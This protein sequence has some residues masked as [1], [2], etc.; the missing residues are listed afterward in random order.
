M[1]H[2]TKFVKFLTESEEWDRDDLDD[3]LRP[4]KDMGIEVSV[5]DKKPILNGENEGR[6][7]TIIR[8]GI[9]GLKGVYFPSF[10]GITEFINDERIWEILDEVLTI[11]SRLES[12]NV[13]IN[14]TSNSI[15]LSYLHGKSDT[16][17]LDF[18]LKKIKHLID[19]KHLNSNTDFSHGITVKIIDKSIVVNCSMY[20]TRRKWNMMVRDIDL[21][22][23]NLDFDEVKDSCK[24][25]ITPK[26][27]K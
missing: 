14:F 18:R 2:I 10:L 19:V 1:K 5:S 22:D 26:N 8:I 15:E 17:K 16:N 25:T 3:F 9:G 23:Y 27:N 6:Y 11:K 24:I 13:Y 12:D 20:Y 7:F 4:I 21:S